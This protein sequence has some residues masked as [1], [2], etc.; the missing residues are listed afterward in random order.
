[1]KNLFPLKKLKHKMKKRNP[2]KY[3]EKKINTKRFASSAL[4][5]MTKL[6]NEN[7]L[8][9][10]INTMKTAVGKSYKKKMMNCK[11]LRKYQEK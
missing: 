8:I 4:P 3:E 1:M 5:Y 2:M 6:L 7:Y 10:I 11:I 9:I